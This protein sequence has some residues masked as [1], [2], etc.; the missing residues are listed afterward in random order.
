MVKILLSD[1]NSGKNSQTEVPHV[2]SVVI[3]AS[4]GLVSEKNLVNSKAFVMRVSFL[5]ENL[6]AVPDEDGS[7]NHGQPF[8]SR[9]SEF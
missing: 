1:S 2:Y 7:G 6:F 5:Q 9:R 8:W 4:T 3:Y